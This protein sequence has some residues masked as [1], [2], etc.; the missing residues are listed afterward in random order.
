M[1]LLSHH[2]Q[3]RNLGLRLSQ[4]GSSLMVYRKGRVLGSIQADR[5]DYDITEALRSLQAER[6]QT[7]NQRFELIL[8]RV[9]ARTFEDWRVARGGRRRHASPTQKLR[10]LISLFHP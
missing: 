6:R 8:E 3:A 7:V 5:H 2:V 9:R 1:V 10:T 4:V